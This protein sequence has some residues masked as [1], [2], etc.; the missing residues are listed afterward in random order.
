ME[1]LTHTFSIRA[2]LTLLKEGRRMTVEEI[3]EAI[4]EPQGSVVHAI[5][6][7]R[8]AD[9]V[10]AKARRAEPY[11]ED[12]SLTPAGRITAEKLKEIESVIGWTGHGGVT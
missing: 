10:E 2:L 12:V 9:L 8:E 5:D 1:S 7:L 4:G 11:I 3:A 6:V